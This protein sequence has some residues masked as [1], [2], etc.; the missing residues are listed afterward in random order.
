MFSPDARAWTSPRT[1]GRPSL[2]VSRI[3]AGQVRGEDLM[4]GVELVAN[5]ATKAAFDPA[6]KVGSAF[7]G[8]ALENDLIIRAM[9]D[10]IGL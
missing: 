3:C 8:Q 4:F 6:L 2:R 7:D 9:G 10:T 5:P 1:A